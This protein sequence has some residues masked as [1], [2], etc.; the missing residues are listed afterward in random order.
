M[1]VGGQAVVYHRNVGGGLRS[2]NAGGGRS[3]ES[4]EAFSRSLRFLILETPRGGLR[5]WALR[6][7]FRGSVFCVVPPLQLQVMIPI[8]PRLFAAL[9]SPVLNLF[10]TIVLRGGAGTA[11]YYQKTV[12]GIQSHWSVHTRALDHAISQVTQG[13]EYQNHLG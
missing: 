2:G 4:F 1:G 3:S 12:A 8:V 10:P 9:P 7:L 11:G 6:H 13:P 5:V